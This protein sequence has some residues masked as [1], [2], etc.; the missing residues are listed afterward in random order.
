MNTGNAM[1]STV[2]NQLIA[3]RQ[4]ELAE[5][6]GRTPTIVGIETK[7]VADAFMP[8]KPVFSTAC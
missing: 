4:I 7:F 6:A 8:R 1:K 3:R 2:Y 5:R